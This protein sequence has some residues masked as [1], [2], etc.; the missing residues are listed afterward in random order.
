MKQKRTT[1][2]SGNKKSSLAQTL[3][4]FTSLLE[5]ANFN[6]NLN[7]KQL[8]YKKFYADNLVAKMDMNDNFVNLKD[9]RLQ[10]A[11]GSVLMQG[12]VRNEPASNPFSFKL[13]SPVVKN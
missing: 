6:L 5:D 8:I 4:E 10:H 3:T 2:S 13:C 12:I 7:A 9:I 1:A 11:G